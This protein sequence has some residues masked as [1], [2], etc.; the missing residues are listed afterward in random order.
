MNMHAIRMLFLKDLFLSRR[1]LF[2]Y[3]VAGLAS[4]GLA[5]TPNPTLA[6]VGFI[7]MITVAIASGIHF[8]G[9][10][11]LGESTDHT[12][13]FVMSLPVSLLDYS[14][15]KI[16]VV[17]TTYL[18]PWSTMLACLTVL[19]FLVPDAKHGSA[20]LL[21]VIFLFLLS[22]FMIQLVTAVASDSVGWTIS[23][24]VACNVAMNVFLMQLFKNAEITA[25]TKADAITWP[26]ILL[27]IITLE[28]LVILTSLGLTFFLQTRKRDLI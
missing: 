5:C 7:L 2:G 26:P 19:T 6:F 27:Q 15:G 10:L 21:P 24:M 3:F 12:K 23:V 25:A 14:I 18:I 22:T 17:L 8:I 20:V 4:V 9:I 28:C 16:S 11:L 13:L 1:Y